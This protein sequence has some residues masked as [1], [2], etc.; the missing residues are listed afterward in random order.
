MK[1]LALDIGIE[2]APTF[3]SYVSGANGAAVAQLRHATT[4]SAP[5]YLW[6]PAGAGKTHLLHA[7]ARH[8]IDEGGRVAWFDAT[9]P[10]P[11]TV[12]G[13]PAL[14][15]LDQ[16]EAYDAARQQAAFTLFV[17]A[18]SS[19]APVLAAGRVPPVDL[20][21][22]DDLRSRLG[23]GL[24]FAI[25][26]LSE[27]ETR[28][29]LRRDADHRGLFLSDE[30]MDYLLH[31]FDRDLKHLTAR[32]DQLDAYSLVQKRAITVPLLRQMLNE[33]SDDH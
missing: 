29:A 10:T 13:R 7:A 31:R 14:I 11:W 8:A 27:A 33:E 28:A 2:K 26:P 19:G 18:A 6:G 16:C 20:P 24:V 17:E 32:L 1:Q 4:A 25:Q 22:R 12:A 21:L 30:V 9:S 15:V 23:W 3:E 5:L